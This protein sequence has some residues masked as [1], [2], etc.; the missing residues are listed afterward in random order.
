MLAFIVCVAVVF[1]AA[2]FGAR[3]QVGDWYAGLAKPSWTPP[4]A[5]FGPV[6]TLLYAM[7]AVSAALVWR[8]AGF[9]AAWKPL[10]VFAVQLVLNAAWSWLFFGLHRP[11]AAFG[12]ILILWTAILITLVLFWRVRPISGV[13][14]L[15]YWAWVSFAAALNFSI[16]Q[17]NR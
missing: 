14:L 5:L 2:F 4:N 15:P 9:G 1:A 10:T 8:K 13:L 17:L 11:G 3:F 6:W 16:W 7:M 12:E